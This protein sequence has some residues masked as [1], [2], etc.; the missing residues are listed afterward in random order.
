MPILANW[1]EKYPDILSSV[2][3]A[4]V[5]KIAAKSSKTCSKFL[6]LLNSKFKIYTTSTKYGLRLFICGLI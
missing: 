6:L 1:S 3:F 2:F 4:T 5:K